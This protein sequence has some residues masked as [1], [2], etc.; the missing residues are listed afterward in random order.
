MQLKEIDRNKITEHKKRLDKHKKA[1]ESDVSNS[2]MAV[3]PSA[4]RLVRSPTAGAS[5]LT[6]Q[7]QSVILSKEVMTQ[8]KTVNDN[9]VTKKRTTKKKIIDKKAMNER[10][11]V[12]AE[13]LMDD[14]HKGN[15][16]IGRNI[17]EYPEESKIVIT[18]E[19]RAERFK[20]LHAMVQEM[21]NKSNE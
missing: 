11:K 16:N 1:I 4:V 8:E 3:V 13:K 2:N 21:M 12:I 20:R 10:H 17:K 9:G 19:E 18:K 6:Q 7:T 14:V 5:R 15:I